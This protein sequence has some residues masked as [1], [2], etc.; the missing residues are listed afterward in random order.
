MAKIMELAR[1]LAELAQKE[2]ARRA[3][4]LALQQQGLT[5]E[6]ELEAACYL[7]FSKGDYQVAYTTLVNLHRRG[8][9]P[10]ECLDLL[11]RAFYQPN[12]KLLRSRYEKNCKLLQKYPYLF[13]RDFL[14]FEALPVRFY[15]YDDRGYVPF[16]VEAERPTCL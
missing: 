15:P 9:Y 13:R 11:T 2:D 8:S 6:E 16:S 7:L 1:R 10:R 12:E 5:P 3:Y 4:T 14:P